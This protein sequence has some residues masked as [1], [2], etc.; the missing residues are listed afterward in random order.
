MLKQLRHVIKRHAGGRRPGAKIIAWAARGYY[1]AYM[2]AENY[3]HR[4]NGE[5]YLLDALQQF[6]FQT[7]FDVGAN[8]GGWTDAALERWSDAQVHAFEI[9]RP[10]ADKLRKRLDGHPRVIING[11]GLSDRAGDI[12]IQHFPDFSTSTT[13]QTEKLKPQWDSE[14][15]PAEVQ[16]GAQYL[17]DADADIALMKVDCEGH[18]LAVLRGFG[19]AVHAIPVIQFEFN[20]FGLSGGVVLKDFYDCLPDHRIGRLLPHGVA[21]AAY[22]SKPDV[23]LPGNFVAVRGDRPDIIDAVAWRD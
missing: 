12:E 23:G 3:G 8:Q 10:T 16:T 6:E 15:L 18:D 21:F 7:I 11:F 19:D 17:A 1:L 5:I 4:S 14:I 13:T 9:S 2:N 20:E 22:E